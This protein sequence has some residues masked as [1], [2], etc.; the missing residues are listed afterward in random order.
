MPDH[1]LKSQVATHHQTLFGIEGEGGIVRQVAD[2]EKRLNKLDLK[3]LA[4]T[5]LAAILGASLG[6]TLLQFLHTLTL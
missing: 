1:E 4:L 3:H 2:H 5:F 6:S